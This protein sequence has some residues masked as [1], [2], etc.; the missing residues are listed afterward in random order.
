M[1]GFYYIWNR[2]DTRSVRR[3]C[4]TG[5]WTDMRNEIFAIGFG[6]RIIGTEINKKKQVVQS[7]NTGLLLDM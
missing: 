6:T 1:I 2:Y 5:A 7:R 4:K 3:N